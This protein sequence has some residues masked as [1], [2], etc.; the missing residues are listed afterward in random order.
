MIPPMRLR[1]LGDRT[2]AVAPRLIARDR[3]VLG[4]LGTL[5]FFQL[6]YILLANAPDNVSD[7]MEYQQIGHHFGSWWSSGDGRRTPGYPFFLAVSY[8]LHLGNTGV[9]VVQAI[10]VLAVTVAVSMLVG[11]ASGLT[12]ARVAAWAQAFYLPFF[13]YSAAIMSDVAAVAASTVGVLF[14]VLALRPGRLN[15]WY[16][17][18]AGV[19]MVIATIIRPVNL[20]FLMVTLA[21]LLLRSETWRSRLAT[22]SIF[23]ICFV[24]I[25]GPWVGRNYARSSQAWVLGNTGHVQLAWG[26]HLPWDKRVG[27]FA[28][29]D[30]SVAFYSHTR[31]DGFDPEAALDLKVWPTLRDDLTHH[32]GEFLWSRVIAQGQLWVWPVTARTQFD[33]DDRIPYPLIMAEHLALL[34]LGIAGLVIMRRHVA[35][36]MMGLL[37]LVTV[38]EYLFYYPGPRYAFAVTPFIV[39]A[40]GVTLSALVSRWRRDRFRESGSPGPQRVSEREYPAHV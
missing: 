17:T 21:V 23:A 2:R 18:A 12:A 28:H 38:V 1:L 37:V 19:L 32:T 33:E 22:I 27:E 14:V 34:I 6:L 40:S 24:L 39:G 26:L 8:K 36:R 30:R 3:W 31:L 29:W 5:L 20:I 7:E 11:V 10:F 13:S 15:Y 9:K 16:V 25:F 4:A 35:G